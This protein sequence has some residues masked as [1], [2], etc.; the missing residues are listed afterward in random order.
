[1]ARGGCR[2]RCALLASRD[3]GLEKYELALVV[4]AVGAALLIVSLMNPAAVL[5]SVGFLLYAMLTALGLDSALNTI[6]PGWIYAIVLLVWGG[7]CLAQTMQQA[8]DR[9]GTEPGHGEAEPSLA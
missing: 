5:G 4:G 9:R 1:V 6:S 8:E 2:P 3:W 7:I